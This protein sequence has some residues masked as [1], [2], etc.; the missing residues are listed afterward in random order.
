M[1][2]LFIIG[3]LISGAVVVG[4]WDVEDAVLE[5][6]RYCEM[7]EAKAWPDYKDLEGECDVE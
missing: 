4:R 1:F 5:M 2:K 3:L 7:V 6:T